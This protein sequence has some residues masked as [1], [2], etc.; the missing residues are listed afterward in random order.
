MPVY[1]DAASVRILMTRFPHERLGELFVVIVDDGSINNAPSV[2]GLAPG[3]LNGLIIKLT[4]NVG[5]QTAIAVGLWFVL[6]N[7]TVTDT[8][9]VM[10]SD[11]EDSPEHM[12]LLKTNLS[13]SNSDVAVAQRKKRTEPFPFPVFYYIYRAF[14]S[15]LTGQSL[16]F[17]NFIA[18]RPSAVSA[19][20]NNPMLSL[21]I[22]SSVLA[23]NVTITHVP[24]DRGRR[25]FGSSKMNFLGL[26]THG[27][28]ALGP[29]L[30]TV[31]LRIGFV[32][33]IFGLTT[34]LSM[35]LTLATK[36]LGI[37][38]P[39]WTSLFLGILSLILIQFGFVLM[40]IIIF[41]GFLRVFAL[42]KAPNYQL[43]VR[44]VYPFGCAD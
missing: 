5:H 2:E 24:L 38:L 28:R 34:I 11:G 22:A 41:S 33:L 29:F 14:F 8:I 19:L 20:L 39:G 35:I 9:F 25:F 15:L 17:G 27:F 12:E 42:D 16:M 37:S 18:F 40:L 36:V 31:L 43:L 4:R 13:E 6:K 44:Q 10:D 1:E 7:Y 32:T 26:I 3:D 21:H 23:S 30:E